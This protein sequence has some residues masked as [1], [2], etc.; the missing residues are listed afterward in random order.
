MNLYKAQRIRFSFIPISLSQIGL[1][2][3]QQTLDVSNLRIKIGNHTFN[4]L[5]ESGFD[6][7]NP[8]TYRRSD[9]SLRSLFFECN[10]VNGTIVVSSTCSWASLLYQISHSIE[11]GI[12]DFW[13]SDLKTEDEACNFFTYIE[14]AKT[15]RAFYSMKD[16]RWKFYQCGIPLWFENLEYY[17]ERII[18]RRVNR[19]ILTEYCHALNLEIEKDAFWEIKGDSIIYEYYWEK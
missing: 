6:C 11:Q 10:S 17:K 16:P 7:L 13:I 9:N 14:N 2:L 3:K 1:I 4:D 12:Y 19:A 15:Q 18:G 8:Q 5:F